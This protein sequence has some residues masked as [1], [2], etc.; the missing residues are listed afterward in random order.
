MCAKITKNRY[1]FLNV[2]VFYILSRKCNHGGTNIL[3][4]LNV[5]CCQGTCQ[6]L[7]NPVYHVTGY[8]FVF[9]RLDWAVSY[10]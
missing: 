8:V 2:V 3:L 7:H 4:L 5:N 1:G 9:Y 6:V 10:C